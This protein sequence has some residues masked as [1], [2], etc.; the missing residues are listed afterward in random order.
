VR[1]S[2]VLIIGGFFVIVLYNI[3]YVLELLPSNAPVQLMIAET[4]V[5]FLACILVGVGMVSYY[6]KSQ[7]YISRPRK[8][9]L[10]ERN[11]T[12]YR[13]VVKD[14]IEGSEK[15]VFG[16]ETSTFRDACLAS[17]QFKSV[18]RNSKWFVKDSLGNDITYNLLSTS[19]GI[20][21]IFPEYDAAPDS[22]SSE[23]ISEYSEI[24]DSVEYYD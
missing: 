5:L 8:D 17:W 22:E 23:Q 14:G 11:S 19:D 21:T 24:N 10:T 20:A 3:V 7:R 9:T 2:F 15:L 4:V 18:K 12:V 1:T 16:S 13:R 6:P